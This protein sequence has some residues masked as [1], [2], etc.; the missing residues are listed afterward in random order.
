M[1]SFPG[2]GDVYKRQVY[3]E[4]TITGIYGREL[5]TTWTQVTNLLNTGKI[6]LSKYVAKIMR[7]EDLSLI[8]I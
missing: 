1:F 6:D 3:K 4:L 8:H 2:K 5:Y 7:L